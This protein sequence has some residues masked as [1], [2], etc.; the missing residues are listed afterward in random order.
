VGGRSNY[1]AANS[2]AERVEKRR[3]AKSVKLANAG[4]TKIVNPVTPTSGL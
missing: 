2:I 4:S 1:S 3:R